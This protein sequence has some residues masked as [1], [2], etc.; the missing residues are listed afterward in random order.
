MRCWWL[1]HWPW[2]RPR[3]RNNPYVFIVLSCW[4]RV[5]TFRGCHFL[6]YTCSVVLSKQESP[7]CAA[8]IISLILF[9]G[10]RSKSGSTTRCWL[11]RISGSPA[12]TNLIDIK[13]PRSDSLAF[14][15]EMLVA[16]ERPPCSGN[17]LTEIIDHLEAMFDRCWGSCL[18]DPHQMLRRLNLSE[19]K[20]AP[21]RAER[22]SS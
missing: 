20:T 21:S 14:W 15:P 18:D 17:N 12:C 22:C 1:F 10:G 16:I 6:L 11:N 7:A 3:M 13:I 9:S 19:I 2:A 8:G 5:A 4:L